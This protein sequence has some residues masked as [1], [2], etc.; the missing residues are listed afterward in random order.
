MNCRRVRALVGAVFDSEGHLF[1]GS[2]GDLWE[3]TIDT[4]D[5][6]MA[7]AVVA[8][9]FA[10]LAAL[11]TQATSPASTGAYELAVADHTVYAQMQRIGGS[12]WGW[13]VSARWPGMTRKTDGKSQIATVPH[14]VA[15]Y[16][17]T[18]RSALA[19]F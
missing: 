1:F 2:Q 18:Y 13:I 10:P 9:R 12:G 3:G 14:E 19:A 16:V 11:E 17:S 15:D 6:D 8:S 7:P 5:R 4:S